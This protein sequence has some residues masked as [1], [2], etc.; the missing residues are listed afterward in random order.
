MTLMLL[1]RNT[2][3][4]RSPLPHEKRG[5]EGTNFMPPGQNNE[6]LV[7]SPFQQAKHGPKLRLGTLRPI[8]PLRDLP[9]PFFS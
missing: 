3:H 7:R 4:H 6:D 9:V 8:F 2:T 1:S 5:G